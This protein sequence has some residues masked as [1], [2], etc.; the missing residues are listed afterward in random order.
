M[1]A[2]VATN[3]TWN[4]TAG[5]K[6]TAPTP[7]VGELIVV[8]VAASG[9]TTGLTVSDNQ[10]GGTYTQV[11]T[12]A[13]NNTPAACIGVFVRNNLVTSAVAHTITAGESTSTGGGLCNVRVSGMSKAGLAAIRNVNG[14]YQF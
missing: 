14:T 7:N 13:L 9:M 3:L 4:T 5:N 12:F 11:G 8:I 10:T 2:V 6:T 1:A